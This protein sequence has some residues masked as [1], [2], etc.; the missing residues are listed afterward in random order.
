[1][2]RLPLT[3]SIL[4]LGWLAPACVRGPAGPLLS[5]R[6]EQ[7]GSDTRVSLI[8]APGYKINARLKPALE[9]PDGRV[10]RLDS[11]H[12]TADSAYFFQP[13][14]ALLPGRHSRIKG[15]LRASV[16]DPGQTVC[17]SVAVEL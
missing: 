9:L 11:P 10:L 15:R 16:C 17:R 12:L 3:T 6:A 13:P 4:A 8:A 5:L 1:V 2:R 14:S 7:S